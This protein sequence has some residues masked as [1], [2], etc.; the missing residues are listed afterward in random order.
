MWAYVLGVWIASAG[1]I[2]AY[3]QGVQVISTCYAL[4]GFNPN[5]FSFYLD[6]ALPM[7][8]YLGING[9]LFLRD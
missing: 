2:E 5:V 8:W 9:R 7:A 1:T 3:F 4:T 6:F